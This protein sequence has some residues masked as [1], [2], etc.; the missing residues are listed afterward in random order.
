VH[1]FCAV[2]HLVEES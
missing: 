2:A 1:F